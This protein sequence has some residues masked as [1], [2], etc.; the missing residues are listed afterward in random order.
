MK[1]LLSGEDD[2]VADN[3]TRLAQDEHFRWGDDYFFPGR[4]RTITRII[5]KLDPRRCQVTLGTF[6]P[7]TWKRVSTWYP[8]LDLSLAANDVAAPSQPMKRF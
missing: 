4:T 6:R 2:G 5:T 8:V 1:D 7:P 3:G